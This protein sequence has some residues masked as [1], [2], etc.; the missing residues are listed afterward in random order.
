MTRQERAN[1]NAVKTIEERIKAAQTQIEYLTTAIIAES[2]DDQNIA[3]G[4]ALYKGILK[5]TVEIIGEE[6]M[7]ETAIC[8]LIETAGYGVWR[9]IMGSKGTEPK[10]DGGNWK[11][12]KSNYK[13]L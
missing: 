8:Q 13:R 6:K 12:A 1:D 3:N 2:I 11:P 4:L 5:S 10:E 7:T 9:A